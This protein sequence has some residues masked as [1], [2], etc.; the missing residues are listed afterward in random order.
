MT[1]IPDYSKN[2]SGTDDCCGNCREY[3]YFL[4]V[5]KCK[6]L[7]E[8]FPDHK[9]TAEGICPSHDRATCYKCKAPIHCP[10]GSLCDNCTK[11]L[12]E[13]ENEQVLVNVLTGEVLGKRKDIAPIENEMD[14]I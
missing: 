2:L 14:L 13:E 3:E 7:K 1:R 9:A 10:M 12:I 11:A 4:K 6:L 5:P 8:K